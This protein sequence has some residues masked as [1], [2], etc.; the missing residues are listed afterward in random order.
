MSKRFIIIKGLS[1]YDTLRVFSD[2][3]KNELEKLGNIV[4]VFDLTDKNVTQTIQAE[5]NNKVDGIISFNGIGVETKINGM[6]L[7]EFF[8]TRFYAYIV[9][10]AMRHVSRIEVPMNNMN[11]IAVDY[12]HCCYV[13]EYIKSVTNSYMI[14]LGGMEADVKVPFDDRSIDVLFTGSYVNPAENL[15]QLEGHS[16]IIKNVAYGEIDCMLN[17]SGLSEEE[18]FYKYFNDNNL[19]EMCDAIQDF[20]IELVE[21]DSYVR[22]YRRHRLIET[23]V[24][25]G[26]KINV[27]GNGWENF[28]C[29]NRENLIIGSAVNYYEN[30]NLMAN[31]KIVLNIMPEFKKGTHDRVFCAM[32][33]KA[34]CLTDKSTYNVE[35]FTDG[36]DIVFYDVDNMAELP[37]IINWILNDTELAKKIAL[38]GYENA[39]K[40]HRWS[41][42]VEAFLETL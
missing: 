15:K 35:N 33:N 38:K 24:N 9:D 7:S 23:I 40:N 31:S 37:N 41:N 19:S 21:I 14:P 13:N 27:Y 3:I 25:A 30:L 1:Q 34:V 2:Q 18:A 28:K 17:N 26:I 20:M 8:D 16:D 36:E 11:V 4:T 29:E 22:N 39:D 6:Y 12:D 10:H 5:V 32:L 42:R